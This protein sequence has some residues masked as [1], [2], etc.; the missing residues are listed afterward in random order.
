MLEKIT[1]EKHSEKSNGR[2]QPARVRARSFIDFCA[3]ETAATLRDPGSV[4]FYRKC[5]RRDPEAAK[6][7]LYR[8]QNVSNFDFLRKPGA[9][10]VWHW[11]NLMAGQPREV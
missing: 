8:T 11:K 4:R 3:K 9:M 1:F 5:Y 10:F 6:I 7:A 2:P